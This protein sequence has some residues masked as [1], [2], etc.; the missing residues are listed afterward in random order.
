MTT[1]Q[2]ISGALLLAGL[3]VGAR[4]PWGLQSEPPSVGGYLILTGDF[5]VH[6]YPG[7]GALTPR[8]LRDLAA[9]KGL[10]VIA[11]TNHNQTLA[12]RLLP[13]GDGP[14]VLLGEE[15][16]NPDFHLIAVGITHDVDW[17]QPA[18]KAIADIHEQGGVAIVAH[19]E[20]AFWKG[21]DA[22]AMATVDGVEVAHPMLREVGSAAEF[23]DFFA[24]VQAGNPAVARIGSSDYHIGQAPGECR[25]YL[26]ARERSRGGVLDAIRSGRTVARR[27]DGTLLGDPALVQLVS[28][29]VNLEDA[30]T[31]P[32]A[33]FSAL[34]AWAG[35]AGLMLSLPGPT[36]PSLGSEPGT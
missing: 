9:S 25:T 24:R 6:A 7:D 14:I 13:A 26:F 2:A 29:H 30:A 35:I 5:H 12:S 23:D 31:P 19:P 11:I 32:F 18:V 27:A 34:C 16:T 4:V 33:L 36:P 8:Q 3:V 28:A 1:T 20:R 22:P 21:W 17:D 10:D 15:V